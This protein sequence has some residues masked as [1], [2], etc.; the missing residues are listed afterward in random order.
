MQPANAISSIPLLPS[1]INLEATLSFACLSLLPV[2]TRIS[3]HE[4]C[5]FT[6]LHVAASLP[7]HPHGGALHL[8]T[9]QSAQHQG[10]SRAG[11]DAAGRGHRGSGARIGL[12]KTQSCRWK[13]EVWLTSNDLNG[14]MAICNAREAHQRVEPSS[15]R[16]LLS[17]LGSI[18][19][20]ST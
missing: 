3:C 18:Y 4:R 16:S 13:S 5:T 19:I 8:L 20:L 6:Y 17:P 12:Q 11:L 14:Q 10:I 1:T 15:I 2:C 9:A 7:H